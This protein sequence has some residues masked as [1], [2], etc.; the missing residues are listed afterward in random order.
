MMVGGL[1]CVIWGKIKESKC[2]PTIEEGK[3]SYAD[4][5]IASPHLPL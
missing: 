5:E 1:Y 3:E 2:E 4:R